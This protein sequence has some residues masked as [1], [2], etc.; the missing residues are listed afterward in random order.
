[1][2]EAREHRGF[3]VESL[4]LV[5]FRERLIQ[6]LERDVTAYEFVT[7]LVDDPRSPATERAGDSILADSSARHGHSAPMLGWGESYSTTH[8]A[9]CQRR[10]V[11]TTCHK[12]N[13][14]IDA[15]LT[16]RGLKNAASW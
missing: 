10:E 3:V 16:E 6:D 1:M 12:C 8:A 11:R 2:V 7:R 13:H 15:E 9:R 4:A 14:G 5:R